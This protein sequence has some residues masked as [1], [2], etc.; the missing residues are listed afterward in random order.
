MK[1][2]RVATA[3]TSSGFRLSRRA[4][5]RIS[6]VEGIRYSKALKSEFAAYDRQGLTSTEKAAAIRE[7]YG[8]RAG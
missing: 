6:A 1:K 7:K 2:D 4:F 8:K 5:E 3:K